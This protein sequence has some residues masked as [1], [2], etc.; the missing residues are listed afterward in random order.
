MLKITNSQ[1]QSYSDCRVFYT[2]LYLAPTLLFTVQP[3]MRV[4]DY[5]H[6]VST[7]AKKPET[8]VLCAGGVFLEI[9]SRN[10]FPMD[11]V[12]RKLNVHFEVYS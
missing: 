9:S 8:L 7:V 1:T 4:L 12:A 6:L 5:Q 10:H 2:Q 11:C 3:H